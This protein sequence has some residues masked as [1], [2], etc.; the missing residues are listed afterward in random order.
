M[1][2]STLTL[3][4]T[5][6]PSEVAPGLW[7]TRWTFNGSGVGPTL[8]GRVGD[9]FDITLVN[10]GTMGHSI[11][12][13]RAPW[14]P[15]GPCAPSRPARPSPTG[16]PR[17]LAGIWMYHCSTMPMS[18][19][20]AAGMTGAVV[21]EP[22]GLEPVDRSYVLVQS[23]VY[24]ANAAT[25]PQQ[26]R[27]VD[28]TRSSPSVPTGWCSTASPTSTTTPFAAKVGE[29]VRFW[30]LDAG[31]NRASAHIVGGQF[32][33]VWTEGTYTLRHGKAALGGSDGGAQVLPL[34]PAQGGFVELSFPEEGHYSVVLMIKWWTP[35]VALTASCRSLA[36]APPPQ[37]RTAGWDRGH[38]PEG[39]L[40]C[41]GRRK[42]LN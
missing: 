4:V 10:D 20:I 9:V 25:D 3:R 6:V 39:A 34:Q 13:M 1:S 37:Q 24:L 26:A 15:I 31:P 35:N 8:H 16:S 38:R 18:T 33:T 5:E 19:H 30:V 11:D 41:A 23:E 29:R 14:H 17:K 2:G 36:E 12:F 27:E 28:R 7:Q 22:D 32:D 40:N 42:V 21:I